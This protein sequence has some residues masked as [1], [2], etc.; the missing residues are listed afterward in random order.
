M[1]IVLRCSLLIGVLLFFI[2][3]IV[4]IRKK[5]FSLKHSLLWLLAGTCLLISAIFPEIIDTLSS[6][7]GI[8]SPVNT[9][10]VLIIF[11]ILVI[12]MSITS[13]V[14]KQS[15]KIKRL[16]QYNALL[17]KRVREMENEKNRIDR[18]A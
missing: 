11:F 18:S 3:I 10:F 17:E 7:L 14:S 15:E 1:N 8:V 13:I 6:I 9:V 4:F 16:A 2:L 5:A 12:L